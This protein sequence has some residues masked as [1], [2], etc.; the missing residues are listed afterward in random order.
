MTFD[1]FDG[2]LFS[3]DHLIAEGF[4]PERDLYFAFSGGEEVNGC[5]AKSI[6]D[7]FEKEG[8]VPALV[9]DEGGAVVENVFPGVK[10]RCGMI[11]IAEKG[12]L[13]VLYR[14][15]SNGG[16]ASAPKPHTPVGILSRACCAV[17]NHPFSAHMTPPVAKMFDTLGRHSTFLY[18][19]IFSNVIN[20]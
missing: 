8:I 15:K 9:L 4:T 18:K 11:G 6:V 10:G 12:M 16:H 19:I 1:I 14:A 5:G 13:D 20:P 17:E 7:W 3:A 2:I